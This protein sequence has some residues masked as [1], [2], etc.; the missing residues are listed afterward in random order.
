E[1]GLDEPKHEATLELGLAFRDHKS[2][3]AS[4]V[5]DNTHPPGPAPESLFALP[6]DA[7]EGGYSV[8]RDPHLV[9]GL[10]RTALELADAYLEHEKVGKATR[11]RVARLIQAYAGLDN[12]SAHAGGSTL[13]A[14][15]ARDKNAPPARA[16]W[17]VMRTSAA[18]SSPLKG[19][20]AD[21]AGV[22]SDKDFRAALA[23]R[24]RT[25]D[26]SLP[27]ARTVPIKGVGIWPGSVA[28]VVKMPMGLAQMITGAIGWKGQK[29]DD[30]PVEVAIAVVPSGPDALLAYAPNVKELT[31]RLVQA[32]NPKSETLA[33]RTELERM[34]HM[35][36]T[37]AGF[38]TL[39]Y[40]LGT[41]SFTRKLGNPDAAF[42]ALPHHGQAPIFLEWLTEPGAAPKAVLRT[43]VTGG[44][45]EDLPGLVPLL[46]TAVASSGALH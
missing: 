18:P 7:G 26:K 9:D 22:L 23:R 12:A 13:I 15:S 14:K 19:F 10:R 40:L 8:G 33:T 20:A 29:L 28:A 44:V 25:D 24:L 21:L 2:W 37:Q 31:A 35:K 3:V 38:L 6:E 34:R 41:S 16:P 36:A 42:A 39:S 17:M 5:A 11:D 32:L 45:F 43:T 46:A 30:G 1:G 27:T 4:V